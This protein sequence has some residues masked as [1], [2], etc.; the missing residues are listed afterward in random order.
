M[1]TKIFVLLVSISLLVGILSG[2]TE[3]NNE[4][5][6]NEAPVASFTVPDNVYLN[7]GFT[8]TD[9]STDDDGVESWYWDFGD[10]TNLTQQNPTHTYTE[11]GDYEITLTVTDAEGL[12]DSATK[13]ITVGYTP[14]TARFTYN[15][16]INITVNITAI[17][18]TDTSIIGDAAISNWTWNFGDGSA[19]IYSQNTTHIYTT[20]G[21]YTV[22][23]TITDENKLTGTASEEITVTVEIT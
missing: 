14:P 15:P 16:M 6:T 8:L 20:V 7:T 3:E 22:T 10:E 13:T 19:M 17:T 2:C 4:T 1:K 9:T 12:T 21:S 11:I 5:P 18:F 23:L